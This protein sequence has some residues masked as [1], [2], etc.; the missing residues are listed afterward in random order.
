MKG[1]RAS[2]VGRIG[3]GGDRGEGQA[4]QWEVNHFWAGVGKGRKLGS[5]NMPQEVTGDDSES[6]C[7]PQIR[8]QGLRWLSLSQ[9]QRAIQF[10]LSLGFSKQ[11]SRPS[12]ACLAV[13]ENTR[14]TDTSRSL[15]PAALHKTSGLTMDRQRNLQVR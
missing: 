3:G 14:G 13:T 9:E 8:W 1:R 2:C 11:Q 7:C 5:R 10:H 15:K 6:F 12:L 4:A